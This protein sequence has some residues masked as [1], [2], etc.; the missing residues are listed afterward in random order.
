MLKC[1]LHQND[2][3]TCQKCKANARAR[4]YRKGKGKITRQK[5]EKK[6]LENGGREI[7]RKSLRK[8][9][10]KKYNEDIEYR[11]IHIQRQRISEIIKSNSRSQNTLELIGCSAS[12]LKHHLESQFDQSMNWSNYGTYWEV[13]HKFP[14][15]KAIEISID[16]F[17]ECCNYKNLQPL[18]IEDNRVKSNKIVA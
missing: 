15:S 5:Y 3:N 17:N 16:K 8:Y 1:K 4:K 18:K 7:R 13:D 6:W 12:Y 11:L 9:R 14:L 2:P 10:K